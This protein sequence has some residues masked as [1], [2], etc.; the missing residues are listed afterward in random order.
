[1][2]TFQVVAACVAIGLLAYLF[3]AMLKPEKFS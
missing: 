1:M 3:V 2:I